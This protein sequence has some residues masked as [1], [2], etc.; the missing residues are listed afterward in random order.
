MSE[1]RCTGCREIKD[2]SEFHKRAESPNGRTARCKACARLEKRLAREVERLE[3]PASARGP[4]GSGDRKRRGG[5]TDD[6]FG[7]SGKWLSVAL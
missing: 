4:G 7:D 2:Y 6:P 3:Y 5:G 1:K